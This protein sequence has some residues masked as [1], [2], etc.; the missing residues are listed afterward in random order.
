MIRGLYVW[1]LSFCLTLSRFVYQNF[2]SFWGWIVRSCNRD[3]VLC[4]SADGRLGCFHFSVTMDYAPVNTQV[5][6]LRGHMSPY[7]L[8]DTLKW[9]CWVPGEH[10]WLRVQLFDCQAVFQGSRT[11]LRSQPQCVRVLASPPCQRS[12]LLSIFLFLAI[13]VGVKWYLVVLSYVSLMTND[14]EHLFMSL[15][16]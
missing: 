1:L 6:A 2:V 4:S 11:V 7:P 9:N 12:L 3:V 13:V 8:V 14:A 16:A 5:Q 10:C 15:L